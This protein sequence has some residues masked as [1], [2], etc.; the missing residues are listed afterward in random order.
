MHFPPGDGCRGSWWQR[1]L[2][3][4]PVGL[5]V[6]VCNVA[7]GASD[8]LTFTSKNVATPSVTFSAVILGAPFHTID[9]L[10]HKIIDYGV[11]K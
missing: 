9:E 4:L 6:I 2:N 11:E 10:Y 3:S 8:H 5:Q 7:F 1:E